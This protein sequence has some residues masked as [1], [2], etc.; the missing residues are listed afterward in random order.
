[1]T[2]VTL[3][4]RLGHLS[5][6]LVAL[7]SSPVPSDQFQYLADNAQKVIA[8]DYL[9]ICLVDPDSVEGRLAYRVHSL[10]GSAAGAIPRRQFQIDEGIAGHV[11]RTKEPS[12]SQDLTAD[13]HSCPHLEGILGKLGINANLVVPLHQDERPLGA[14]YFAARSGTSYE[15]ADQEI[16]CKLADGLSGALEN[17]RIYQL[18]ADDRSTLEAVLRSTQDAVMLV[19]VQGRV[20]M[21]NPAVRD[22]FGLDETEIV[23][24]S[25]Q[26]TVDNRDLIRLFAGGQPGVVEVPLP[27]GRTAQASLVRVGTSFGEQIGWAA[28][29]RDISVLKQ[30]EQ[31]KNDFVNTVSHDLKNPIS[32]ILLAA[33]LVER[34]GP[35]TPDQ[36]RMHKRITETANYM[37]ELVN[38]LL[39]LGRIST[40]LDMDTTPVDMIQLVEEVVGALSAQIEEKGHYV[41]LDLPQTADINGNYGRLKQVLLNLVGNAIKYTPD[42][43]TITVTMTTVEPNALDET[44]YLSDGPSDRP[45]Q[46]SLV[47]VRIQDTGLGIPA[48]D[49]PHIFD[50]FFRVQN[51]ETADIKGTGLGLAIARTIIEAHDGRIWVES[52][53]GQ[54]STFAFYL[55]RK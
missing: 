40:G 46:E 41:N 27:D 47:V 37:S 36:E 51:D 55:P 32:S 33:S 19:N 42:N 48:A 50:R 38:D 18:L 24:R 6:L 39:D 16:A 14:L 4:E 45:E 17:S 11:I 2:P 34:L 15:T 22:M 5:D 8:C 53:E 23:G 43:G 35:L 9:A 20:L 44:T 3:E 7:L 54:G 29:F 1:M 28:V 21:S 52:K 31:M 12:C 10:F 49:L 13:P 25:L 30:L 26:N